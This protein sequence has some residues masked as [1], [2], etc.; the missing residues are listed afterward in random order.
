MSWS[1]L[2]WL[3]QIRRWKKLD[4]L[5]IGG[6]WSCWLSLSFWSLLSAAAVAAI[7]CI[8][9]VMYIKV[10]YCQCLIIFAKSVKSINLAIFLCALEIF[11]VVN[12]LYLQCRLY[13]PCQLQSLVT[14]LGFSAPFMFVC[15]STQYLKNW[16]SQDHHTWHRCVPQ[17]VLETHLLWG[18]KGK[19]HEAQTTSLYWSSDVM[20]YCHLLHM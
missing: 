1:L 7:C 14:W 13:Y 3:V 8:A 6:G 16:C 5:M 11:L 2:W 18:Q 4:S 19:G 9:M 20:H 12:L 10:C 15:L 17:W